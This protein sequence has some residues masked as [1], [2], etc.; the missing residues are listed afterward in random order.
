MQRSK[1]PPNGIESITLFNVACLFPIYHHANQ[2]LEIPL[3]V[4][5]AAL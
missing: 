3:L 2:I 5:I 4:E 1:A